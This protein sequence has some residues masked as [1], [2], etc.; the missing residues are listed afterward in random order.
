M[1]GSLA[2]SK[3][4]V[5]VHESLSVVE[6]V[7]KLWGNLLPIASHHVDVCLEIVL[8][9]LISTGVA[10]MEAT[11]RHGT[12]TLTSALG[13]LAV[14]LGHYILFVALTLGTRL[15]HK[16]I[17]GRAL[18]TPKCHIVF[19][20]LTRSI[21]VRVVRQRG[22]LELVD[23]YRPHR[24]PTACASGMAHEG[25]CQTVVA[26]FVLILNS[27]V[28]VAGESLLK[29]IDHGVKQLELVDGDGK[30]NPT[31]NVI[32]EHRDVVFVACFENLNSKMIQISV[33]IAL[34]QRG[35][36]SLTIVL[37]F[38]PSA[39]C[40]RLDEEGF[41]AT[42]DCDAHIFN[43]L[44]MQNKL[45]MYDLHTLQ[46]RFFYRQNCR[47]HLSSILPKLIKKIATGTTIVFPDD[48]AFKRNAV[49]F[50]GF[51]I[52][53]CNKIRLSNGSKKVVIKD[54]GQYV[55][56]NNCIIVD[57]IGRSGGTLKEC[58]KLLIKATN[59]SA[60]VTHPVFPGTSL[61]GMF[62]CKLF[63]RLYFGN[64]VS[65]TNRRICNCPE[66]FKIVEFIDVFD[67]LMEYDIDARTMKFP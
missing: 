33:L 3:A 64:T 6:E 19:L 18:V 54:G 39:T 13:T 29:P 17:A 2:T 4:V 31:R 58:A 37:P 59:V 45:I 23:E 14:G 40:E 53:V 32:L 61:S 30:P 5:C 15:L 62:T 25:E 8:E 7:G 46:N 56:D 49:F 1:V 42:A 51:D 10:T 48:G 9:L 11:T 12:R 65:E 47:P 43:T 55:K 44:P 41:L 67:D 21:A 57:D 63:D 26:K 24:S 27:T 52:V 60:F 16:L 66:Y 22:V 36:K 50:D 20:V 28:V 35:A 34:S 38:N